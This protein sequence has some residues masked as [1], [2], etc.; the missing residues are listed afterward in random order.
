MGV[1][2]TV[3]AMDG[4]PGAPMDGFT[5]FPKTPMKGASGASTQRP[6]HE[7]FRLLHDQTAA[8]PPTIS[9]SSLVI[10]AWRAL[11]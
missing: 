3:R 10:A 9:A 2:G 7:C 8:A 4:A 11:L 6:A 1:F 5:A